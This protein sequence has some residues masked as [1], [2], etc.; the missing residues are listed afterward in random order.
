MSLTKTGIEYATH[1]GNWQTGCSPAGPGCERCWAV[2]STRR[3]MA[4]AEGAARVPA[5]YRFPLV[6]DAG[7]TRLIVTDPAEMDATFEAIGRKQAPMRVFLGDVTDL[8]HEDV[9]ADLL[10]RL[11]GH[12]QA[13]PTRNRYLLLTK[14][15]R[16]MATWAVDHW[17]SG[18][19]AHIWLG[20]SVENQQ[21]V[22]R[23]R[24]LA[25]IEAG[26]RWVSVEPIIGPVNLRGLDLDWVVVGSESGADARPCDIAWVRDLREQCVIAGVQWWY[27]Q[28]PGDHGP[29]FAHAPMLD[30]RRW[31]DLPAETP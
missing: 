3:I 16:R 4:M 24:I 9:G 28:G 30:G 17:R 8:F 31:T 2:T 7:W 29:G 19:P 11:A 23:A 22:S 25:E 5:R 21:A 26:T 6:D 14:R 1:V 27:K 15:P 13:A 10:A 12:L 20:T 18:V